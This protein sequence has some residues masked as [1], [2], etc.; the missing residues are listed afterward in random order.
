MV[1][2]FEKKLS[3]WKRQYLGGRIT[4]IKGTVSNLSVYSVSLFKMPRTEIDRLDR[5]R[6][7]FLWEGQGN[8]RK[9]YLL[10]WRDVVKLKY[11]SGLGIGCLC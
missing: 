8:R 6:R 10:K 4:L 11:A 5:I 1:E 2:K 3:I 9:I 7:N